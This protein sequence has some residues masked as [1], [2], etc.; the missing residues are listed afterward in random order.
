MSFSRILLIGGLVDATTGPVRYPALLRTGQFF[1]IVGGTLVLASFLVG[2][3]STPALILG[4]VLSFLLASVLLCFFAMA[5]KL[6]GQIAVALVLLFFGACCGLLALG[7]NS[8]QPRPELTARSL[9][10]GKRERSAQQASSTVSRLPESTTETSPPMVE[11]VPAAKDVET[12]SSRTKPFFSQVYA[13]SETRLYYPEDCVARP[14]NAFRIAKS[15]AI[16]QG[17]TLANECA[18]K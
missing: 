1:A 5:A 14:S 6:Y 10:P 11:S 7:S 16:Q 4:A 9:S 8:S 2:G 12:P 17:Y 3:S 15:I 18:P 13:V